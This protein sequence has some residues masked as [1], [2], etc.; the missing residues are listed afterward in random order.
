MKLKPTKQLVQKDLATK[1]IFDA[2][3]AADENVWLE[4]V[5]YESESNKT[6]RHPETMSFRHIFPT[7]LSVF[8]RSFQA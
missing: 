4:R 1:A 3:K 2:I 7:V 5:H 8:E 6:D